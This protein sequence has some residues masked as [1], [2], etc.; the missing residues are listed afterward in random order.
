MIAVIIILQQCES[1]IIGDLLFI[2]ELLNRIWHTSFQ[3]ALRYSTYSGIFRH[4]RDVLEVVQFTEYTELREFVD[5]GDEHEPQIRVKTL[6][7]AVEVPHY[8]PQ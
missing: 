8:L 2:S 4:H 3:F 7:R 5:S 1:L 6:Y